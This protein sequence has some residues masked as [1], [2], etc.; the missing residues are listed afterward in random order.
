MTCPIAPN[1]KRD[2]ADDPDGRKKNRRV[3]IRA[4]KS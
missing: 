3:E 2:G 1:T 4:K